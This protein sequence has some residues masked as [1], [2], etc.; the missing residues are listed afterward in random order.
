MLFQ[1]YLE[2]YYK[3]LNEIENV[4]EALKLIKKFKKNKKKN[5]F[6]WKWRKLIDR[7]SYSY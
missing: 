2:K 4:E 7:F 3:I 5:S 6:V 1:G